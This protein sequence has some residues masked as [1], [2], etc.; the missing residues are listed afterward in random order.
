MKISLLHAQKYFKKWK[1][2]INSN[3]TQAIISPF[4]KSPKRIPS[5]PLSVNGAETLFLD[6]LELRNSTSNYDLITNL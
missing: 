2:K 4:N 5:I 6:R 3:K 1:I